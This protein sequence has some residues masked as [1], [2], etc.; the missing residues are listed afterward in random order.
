MGAPVTDW[1]LRVGCAMCF[2]G[3]GAFGILQK[4]AWASYFAVVGIGSEAAF[5]WMPLVGAWD[6]LMG[7]LV[8]TYPR[9]AIALWMT[10]RAVWTALLRP[11]AGEPIWETLERA[12]N[13]GVPLALLWRMA[14]PRSWREWFSGARFGEFTANNAVRIGHLLR[15]TIVLLLVGHG[16]LS[17]VGK[18]AFIHN[19]ASVLGDRA[20][21]VLPALGWIEI[22]LAAMVALRPSVPLLVFITLWKLAIEFLWV[23]GGALWWEWI[24]RAGGYAAPIALGIL[25]SAEV[26]RHFTART[27]LVPAVAG[28]TPRP[29]S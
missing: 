21:A 11:L 20:A 1:I 5:D 2:I 25:A 8:L 3:H 12:G 19:L 13:Y 17:I 26:R 4:P 28:R 24:E 16:A 9:P 27:E 18:P 22:A 15:V 6:I 23:T 7:V 10:G 29:T 14:P